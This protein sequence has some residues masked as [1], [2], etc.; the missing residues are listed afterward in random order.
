MLGKRNFHF[1]LYY[2]T[3]TVEVLTVRHSPGLLT[4][5]VQMH[6]MRTWCYAHEVNSMSFYLRRSGFVSCYYIDYR[7]SKVRIY[8]RE[9][10]FA[11]LKSILLQHN[12]DS[13]D[14]FDI[15]EQQF[16]TEFLLRHGEKVLRKD[17]DTAF[18]TGI[19]SGSVACLAVTNIGGLILLT[20][21]HVFNSAK[22]HR[23]ETGVFWSELG[24]KGVEPCQV[25]ELYYGVY[26]NE[27][28]EHQYAIDIAALPVKSDVTAMINNVLDP[29]EPPY[30]GSD[31]DLLDLD[32]WKEGATTE[33]TR[34]YI[35]SEKV[36]AYGQTF[37]AVE[38]EPESDITLNCNL[39]FAEK[40]DSGALVR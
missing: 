16:E 20:A 39:K 14:D 30:D 5:D 10:S 31:N 24:S 38:S 34:G 4:V 27:S 21:K 33:H 37:F 6:P 40:G 36:W 25:S 23:E 8:T 1:T 29:L 15:R 22:D 12:V 7:S 9:G 35:V 26:G 3:A 17:D 2:L 11:E 18:R 28:E 19:E 13:S 32:V